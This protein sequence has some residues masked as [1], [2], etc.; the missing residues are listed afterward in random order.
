MLAYC[1]AVTWCCLECW[2]GQVQRTCI[3][4]DWECRCPHGKGYIWGLVC[5]AKCP[6]NL[7]FFKKIRREILHFSREI[8]CALVIILHGAQTCLVDANSWIHRL[9]ARLRGCQSSRKPGSCR[10]SVHYRN[11]ISHLHRLQIQFHITVLSSFCPY[12]KTEISYN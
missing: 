10:Y 11:Q 12:S 9:W 7:A 5:S 8:R 4:W 6:R 3:T 1:S 2:V